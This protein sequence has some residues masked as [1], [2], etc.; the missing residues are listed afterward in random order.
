MMTECESIGGHAEGF[1]EYSMGLRSVR[2]RYIVY[3]YEIV[4]ELA[5]KKLKTE[6]HCKMEVRE[7]IT[8][9]QAFMNLS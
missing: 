4:K 8:S 6:F 2:P 7:G 3:M 5:R 1:V 9:L